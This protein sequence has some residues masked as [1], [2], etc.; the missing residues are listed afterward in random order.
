[1]SP[2]WRGCFAM[3]SLSLRLNAWLP[4]HSTNQNGIDSVP[5]PTELGQRFRGKAGPSAA[6]LLP[7]AVVIRSQGANRSQ[8]YPIDLRR[9]TQMR[10]TSQ[11]KHWK[12]HPAAVVT[13]SCTRWSESEP[14][15]SVSADFCPCLASPPPPPIPS[16][17]FPV[18]HSEREA[19]GLPGLWPLLWACLPLGSPCAK[20]LKNKGLSTEGPRTE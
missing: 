8:D 7:P 20:F 4:L 15:W 3:Q 10:R 17:S 16:S 19:A 2:G 11:R 6:S 12:G 18:T 1:M 9:L 13:A 14:A 5:F